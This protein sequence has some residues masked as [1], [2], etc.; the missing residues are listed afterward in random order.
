MKNDIKLENGVDLASLPVGQQHAIK[1]AYRLTKRLMQKDAVNSVTLMKLELL[2]ERIED[3]RKQLIMLADNPKAVTAGFE[4]LFRQMHRLLDGAEDK[5]FN[6]F[7]W[8]N[9]YRTERDL[10]RLESRLFVFRQVI[11]WISQEIA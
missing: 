6:T 9:S 4:R 5:A 11:Y 10:A 2:Y 1:N 7:S 8:E 3:A